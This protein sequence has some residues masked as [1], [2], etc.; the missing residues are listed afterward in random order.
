MKGHMCSKG[1]NKTSEAPRF[2]FGY[3]TSTFIEHSKYAGC[4]SQ[5][6]QLRPVAADPCQLW[7]IDIIRPMTYNPQKGEWELTDK[8]IIRA[9]IHGTSDV[10]DLLRFQAQLS[11][12]EWII[13]DEISQRY[14][15]LSE[16]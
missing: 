4:D 16:L 6:T 8:H 14:K 5:T 9:S 3:M 11:V 13:R 2:Y 7:Q 15:L 10:N 12:A 1:K